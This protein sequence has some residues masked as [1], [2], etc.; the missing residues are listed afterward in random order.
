M[1]IRRNPEYEAAYVRH[2]DI[3]APSAEE[4]QQTQRRRSLTRRIL[5]GT[6]AVVIVGG[7]VFAGVNA[8]RDT[9]EKQVERGVSYAANNSHVSAIIE[10]K[11]SLQ[12]N[13]AQPAVRVL[14]GQE[15]SLMADAKGAEIEFQ[16]AVDAGYDLDETLPLLATALLHQGKFDKVIALVNAN[17]I[18][19]AEGNAELL[20]LR[21]A[22]Y[23]AQGRETDAQDS[24]NAANEFLPGNPAT[25]LA[26]ARALAAKGKFDDA[27]KALDGI[28][29]NAPQVELLSL[30]G[31]IARATKQPQAAIDNYLA[32]VKLEPGNL[33]VRENLAQAY[34]DQRQL[35]DAD[36]QIKRVL[37]LM[38]QNGNA[39]FIKALIALYRKDTAGA[40]EEAGMAV[41]LQPTDGRFQFLA[42]T[43]ALQLGR[44]PEAQQ[45]LRD[46]V[47][48]LPNNVEARRLLALIYLDKHDGPRADDAFGPVFSTFPTNPEYA[49]IAARIA[50]LRGRPNSAAHAFDQVDAKDPKNVEADVLAA[51]YKFANNDKPG[52]FALLN[53]ARTADPKRA[54]VDVALVKAHLSYNETSEAL[55]AWNVLAQKEPSTAR[56]LNL[57]GAIDLARN[58]RVAA[59]KQ[60][61]SAAAA[62]PH[63][64]PPVSGLAML[65]LRD[66]KPDD[67][68]GRL[69]K[70]VEAN[71]NDVD[72]VLLLVQLEKENG[73]QQDVIAKILDDSLKTNPTSTALRYALV[74]YYVVHNDPNRALVIANAGLANVPDDPKLLQFVGER[75]LA[76]G[77]NDRAV[78]V[79]TKLVDVDASLPTYPLLLGMAQLAAGNGEETLTAFRQALAR[80]PDNLD[81]QLTMVGALTSAGKPDE[82]ARMYYE[83]TRMAPRSPLLTELDADVKLAKKSYPEANLAYRKALTEHPSSRLVLK[84]YNALITA[85]Q[86]GEANTLLV[87]WLKAHPNDEQV[88]RFD[89]DAAMRAK[90]YRRAAADF[91]ALAATHAND[92]QIFNNLAWNLA[93]INDPQAITFAEKANM[94]APN[95]AATSDTF[96]W[97]LVESGDTSKGLPL[98]E[99][100]SLAAPDEL[101]IRLHL[102]KAQIKDGRKDA[103]RTTLNA[104]IAKAPTSEQGKASKALLATL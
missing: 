45:H 12:D 40:D 46:T 52:G 8:R 60:L 29:P 39:H 23:Y 36:T 84:S 95:D 91:R 26:Q 57:R 75:A 86:R 65:D 16:K 73:N 34:L 71:P 90:D 53:A 21:G 15:L 22:S 70:F 56:T 104:L 35:E 30:R 38:P 69:R 27:G 47:T 7:A 87:D 102:A 98:I 54:D 32:A 1:K 51:S 31:D 13:P 89:A 59:R 55:A 101:D 58:D 20:A 93:Q 94:L 92:P 72:A 43:L 80:D 103:A 79:F 81:R 63:Y 76:T 10:F 37:T 68:K 100:A 62:D 6:G 99:K 83:I 18:D 42:G 74:D 78:Q 61:E 4:L 49:D 88:R 24:W 67:A 28:S 14:L 82:A 50:T 77:D 44:R 48:L 41:H 3:D 5:L 19:S 64:M 2:T 96:G 17:K 11:R 33:Y 9:S 97:M 85:L 66:R 25:V